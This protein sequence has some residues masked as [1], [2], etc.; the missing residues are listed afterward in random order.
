MSEILPTISDFIFSRYRKI[1]SEFLLKIS[2][3]IFSTYK[4]ITSEILPTILDFIFLIYIKI[5]SETPPLVSDFIFS[6]YKKIKVWN[7]TIMPSKRKE[8]KIIELLLSSPLRYILA[9]VS[10]KPGC[11]VQFIL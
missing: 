11:V 1:K 9:V 7:I 10:S 3:F 8:N 2:D 4:K 5:K 6:T